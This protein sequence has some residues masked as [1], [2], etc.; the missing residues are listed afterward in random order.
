M[1]RTQQQ[2]NHWFWANRT[3]E[4]KNDEQKQKEPTRLILDNIPYVVTPENTPP[5]SPK[6]R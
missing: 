3:I 2:N 1:K 4:T 6:T 5:T